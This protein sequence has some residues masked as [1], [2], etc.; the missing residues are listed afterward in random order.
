MPEDPHLDPNAPDIMAGI[1]DRYL[2]AE[3]FAYRLLR[4]IL[5][6]RQQRREVRDVLADIEVRCRALV[7]RPDADER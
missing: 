7:E 6:A 1:G 5:L 4:L 2:T 3:G